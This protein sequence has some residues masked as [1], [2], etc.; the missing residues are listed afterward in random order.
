LISSHP[1]LIADGPLRATDVKSLML[2]HL[3]DGIVTREPRV[4]EQL[5]L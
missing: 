2:A 4:H 1:E 5:S 3:T